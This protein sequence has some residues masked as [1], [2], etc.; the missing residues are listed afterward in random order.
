MTYLSHLVL[1]G[2]SLGQTPTSLFHGLSSR[3]EFVKFMEFY[4][5]YCDFAKTFLNLS[6]QMEYFTQDVIGLL[7]VAARS[8]LMFIS[9]TSGPVA[10]FAANIPF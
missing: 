1:I 8:R 10:A 5:I 3:S 4:Q 2:P 6:T 9:V 7:V